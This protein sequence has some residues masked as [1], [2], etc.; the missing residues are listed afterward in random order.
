[1]Q[2]L[3]GIAD[4]LAADVAPALA[5]GP[6][7]DQL[8]AAVGMLRRIARTLPGLPAYLLEDLAELRSALV[9]A[10]AA[11]SPGRPL[12]DPGFV[13]VGPAGV[14]SADPGLGGAAAGDE[15]QVRVPPA[16]DAFTTPP[17]AAFGGLDLALVAALPPTL[18]AL[19]TLI[20]WD[21]QLRDV[22]ADRCRV[23]AGGDQDALELL[24]S[25]NRRE[26]ALRLSPWE[27]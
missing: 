18:P 22:L 3:E 7:A 23:A 16:A 21:L 6:A 15:A 24:G 26:A 17:T 27:R 13:G 1:M 2:L 19:D 10:V 11:E 12:P 25:L 5:S 4:A 9:D 20:G 14:G 8:A